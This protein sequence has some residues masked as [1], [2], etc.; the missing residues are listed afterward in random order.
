MSAEKKLKDLGIT[1][2]TPPQPIAN[3]VR[4]VRAGNFLFVSG[5]GPYNDGKIKMVGK[6]GRE[7]TVE[8]GYQL[9]RNVGLNCLATVKAAMGDLDKVKRVVKLLEMVHCTEDFKNQP[10]VINGCSDLLAEIFGEIGKQA[11][12]AVGMQALPNRIPVEIEMI[13]EVA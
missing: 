13:L 1:L 7:L 6:V 10:K 12:L 8:E 5:H 2:P 4:A 11:R 9:A 3:Y